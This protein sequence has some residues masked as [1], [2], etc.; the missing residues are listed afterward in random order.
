MIIYSQDTPTRDS[1]NIVEVLHNVPS[2]RASVSKLTI[3]L[4]SP[5]GNPQS[6]VE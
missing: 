6:Q 5:F 3:G 1:M 4:Q 2:C